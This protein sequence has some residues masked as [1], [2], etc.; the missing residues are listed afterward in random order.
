MKLRAEYTCPLELVQDMIKGKWKPIIL[1]RL[2]HGRSS[3]SQLERTIEGISQKM[4]LEHLKD[5][6]EFEFIEKKTFE[7]YPLKVEYRLTENR[8]QKIIQAL[9][10]MQTMGVEYMKENDMQHI[11]DRIIERKL[12][13]DMILDK[14]NK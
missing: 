1:W 8:G 2:H 9:E 14:E 4:L 5:L 3:L 12:H 13:Y 7:G 10:I 11:L 6:I